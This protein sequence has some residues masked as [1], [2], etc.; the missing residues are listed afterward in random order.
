L[1]SSPVFTPQICVDPKEENGQDIFVLRS[2]FPE[3]EAIFAASPK[4]LEEIKDDC[5]IV[6]DASV[7]L[8]PYTIGPKGLEEVRKTYEGLVAEGRVIIPGQSVRE[9]AKNRATKIG[10]VYQQLLKK[11]SGIPSPELGLY[12]L[13]ES[14]EEYQKAAELEKEIRKSL[15]EYRG[16]IEDL[17]E[18]IREWVW[19]DPVSVLYRD[20]FTADTILDPDFDKEKIEKEL[21]R[22]KRY[23]IPPGYKD[24]TKADGGAGDLL[25][26]YTILEIGSERKKSVIFVSGDEKADWRCRSEKQVLYPR[27]ELFD[28]F[29]RRSEGQTF[30]IV[31]FSRF[32]DL[33]GASE[34]VVEEVRQSEIQV[35]TA[36]REIASRIQESYEY[37]WEVATNAVSEWLT[38]RYPDQKVW[39]LPSGGIYSSRANFVLDPSRTGVYV[40]LFSTVGSAFSSENSL[41]QEASFDIKGGEFSA[42]LIVLVGPDQ[43]KAH[44]LSSKLGRR[45]GVPGVSTVIGYLDSGNVFVPII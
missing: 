40:Y 19:N 45:V 21:E 27:Y 37:W 24:S 43:D 6:L 20:L 29:R 16:L 9:F 5:C 18:H 7:L 31:E 25:I 4:S 42:G 26:W 33:Y 38:E 32:L 8:V 15:G 2:I 13:L 10:E 34:E 22:R 12:P 11:Q 39:E 36:V 14:L 17:L 44:M 35:P 30:H 28:E 1:A 3:A 41:I 23:N